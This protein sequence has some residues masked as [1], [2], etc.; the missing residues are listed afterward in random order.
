MKEILFWVA[1][2]AL[3]LVALLMPFVVPMDQ[4]TITFNHTL[5]IIGFAFALVG[6]Y[7]TGE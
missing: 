4:L 1:G 5:A 3:L 6:V 7:V 2:L